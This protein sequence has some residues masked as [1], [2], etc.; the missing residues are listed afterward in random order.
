M[1]K[2]R[3]IWSHWSVWCKQSKC[4][5]SPS[6]VFL[7]PTNLCVQCDQMLELKVAQKVATAYLY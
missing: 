4:D 6:N 7:D 3:Q 5:I 2:F 1:V